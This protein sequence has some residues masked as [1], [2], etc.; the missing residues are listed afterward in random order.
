[1]LGRAGDDVVP[2]RGILL[3]DAEDRDIVRLGRAARE[4]HIVGGASA[5]GVR[6]LLPGRLDGVGRVGPV[7]VIDAP[8][9]PEPIREVRQHR[10]DHPWICWGGR[11][12]VHVDRISR[13]CAPSPAVCRS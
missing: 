12:V 4:D 3:G 5:D 6:H 1:M 7:A 13:H 9:V 10:L 11:V 2:D 8:G